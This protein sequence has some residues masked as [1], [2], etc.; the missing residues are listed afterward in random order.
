MLVSC[1]DSQP[2][3]PVDANFDSEEIT[4]PAVEPQF[5]D[6]TGTES[7]SGSVSGSGLEPESEPEP[8]PEPEPVIDP[9]SL[10]FFELRLDATRFELLEANE[11]GVIVPIHVNRFDGHVRPVSISVVATSDGAME[12]LVNVLEDSD[13]VGDESY[14]SW[15]A[16][17]EVTIAP[18][19]FHQRSF[20]VR[21]SDGVDSF[22][23]PFEFDVKPVSAPD[24]YLL[25]GQSNMVGSSER[26]ARDFSPGGLDAREPRIRQLNVRQNNRGLFNRDELFTDESFTAMLPRFI[27]AEDPLHEPFFADQPQKGGT[28][29]GLGLSFAKAA[30]VNTTQDIYLVPAAWGATGFCGNEDAPLSWNAELSDEPL[31]GGSLLVERALTRLNMTLRDTGGVLRGILWHQGEAD[32]SNQICAERYEGNLIKLAERLRREAMVDIRGEAA[33]GSQAPIPFI[34]GTMSRGDDERASFSFF[35]DIKQR[36]DDAHRNFP[37]LIPFAATVN[38]DD[39]VPPAYPCGDNSCI[40]FGATAYREL[41]VRYNEALQRAIGIR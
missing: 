8:E 39:L 37:N 31:L 11:S 24:V 9:L 38:A 32:S 3:V 1:K 27:T 21:A 14:T 16:E 26:D 41:G 22:E 20:V 25:I 10:G 6:Q 40:H 30:L 36:V 33:R 35:G 12:N 15:R 19:K 13:L 17:L 5:E 29:I 4:Q 28:H 18:I 7:G 23:L 2:D 34:V